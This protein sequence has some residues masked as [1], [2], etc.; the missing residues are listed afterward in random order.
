MQG[1]GNAQREGWQAA[2]AG[3]REAGGGGTMLLHATTA[4]LKSFAKYV[5]RLKS[6]GGRVINVNDWK[7]VLEFARQFSL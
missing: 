4:H 2:E 7:D 1:K 3:L 5:E 6:Q